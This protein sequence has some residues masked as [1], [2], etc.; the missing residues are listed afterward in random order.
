MC[1]QPLSDVLV[2]MI[3]YDIR[4]YL[5]PRLTRSKSSVTFACLCRSLSCSCFFLSSQRRS[6]M[7]VGFRFAV[8]CYLS[9][10]AIIDEEV[11]NTVCSLQIILATT[12]RLFAKNCINKHTGK[13]TTLASKNLSFGK[14]IPPSTRPWKIAGFLLLYFAWE[15]FE[16]VWLCWEIVTSLLSDVD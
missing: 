9:N 3:F 2:V 10:T 16:N 13:R 12:S 11:E 7:C 6:P 15:P 1:P 4:A 5:L 8:A 14:P